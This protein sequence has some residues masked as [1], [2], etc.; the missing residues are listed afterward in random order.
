MPLILF[1]AGTLLVCSYRENPKTEDK[2]P[3]TQTETTTPVE[4][5]A[6]PV[7]SIDG[8]AL[9]PA[10]GQ[11]GHR[12]DISV[13]RAFKIGFNT[14]KIERPNIGR[15]SGQGKCFTNGLFKS[16]ARATGASL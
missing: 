8:I 13:G 14:C 2:T 7:E 15:C 3:T 9:N 6:T 5:K 10:H 4:K 1:S 12:C 16:S 11:P